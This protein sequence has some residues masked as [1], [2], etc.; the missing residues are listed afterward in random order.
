MPKREFCDEFDVVHA[1]RVHEHDVIVRCDQKI[2]EETEGSAPTFES[3]LRN[4]Q[5]HD[6]LLL[7]L[8][9]HFGA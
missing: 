7:Y 1:R 2:M 4:L 9:Q 3:C 8:Q 6:C 5:Q